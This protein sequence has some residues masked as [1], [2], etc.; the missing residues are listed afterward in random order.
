MGDLIRLYQAMA[1]SDHLDKHDLVQQRANLVRLRSEIQTAICET[2]SMHAAQDVIQSERTEDNLL[3][4]TSEG[5]SP[6]EEI[7]HRLSTMSETGESAA[8]HRELHK[9]QA[10]LRN[11]KKKYIASKKENAKLA[12]EKERM[13]DMLNVI[14]GKIAQAECVFQ[15]V[16][17]DFDKEKKV[18]QDSLDKEK[19]KVLTLQDEKSKLT[20]DYKKKLEK[21]RADLVNE[22]KDLKKTQQATLVEKEKMAK[23]LTNTQKELQVVQGQLRSLQKDLGE[24]SKKVNRANTELKK[25]LHILKNQKNLATKAKGEVEKALHAVKSKQRKLLADYSEWK[26]LTQRD[27]SKVKDLLSKGSQDIHDMKTATLS[28]VTELEPLRKE[29]N[30]RLQEEER[31]KIHVDEAKKALHDALR[32]KHE[33]DICN[34]AQRKETE[35]AKEK[36]EK[37]LA[38]KTKL[39]E[40]FEKHKVES[41]TRIATLQSSTPRTSSSVNNPQTS[42]VQPFPVRASTPVEGVGE[43]ENFESLDHK[44][45]ILR[46]VYNI[47]LDRYNSLRRHHRQCTEV[48][49]TE[50]FALDTINSGI[51]L[52]VGRNTHEAANEVGDLEEKV[53][54]LEEENAELLRRMST[55][56]EAVAKVQK[57][58]QHK[59]TI[60]IH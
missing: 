49:H 42:N 48:E 38:K 22:L 33:Q 41:Q 59:V 34:A 27:V 20:E 44:T 45:K 28:G 60:R 25:E 14:K 43:V 50:D 13:S 29:I 11:V 8:I 40:D 23:L 16:S 36:L 7:P 9:A 5:H 51:S 32:D 18:L 2:G 39:E 24:K 56:A 55:Q 17:D 54:N 37:I 46:E 3:P 31:L 10:D 58:F 57:D 6:L 21:G 47:L 1:S 52:F 15:S 35:R 30:S 4:R 53:K 26:E 12:K 19:T